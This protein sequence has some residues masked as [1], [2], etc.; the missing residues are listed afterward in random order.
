[1]AT[2]AAK[3][4]EHALSVRDTLQHT[5]THTATLTATHAGSGFVATLAAKHVEHALSVRASTTRQWDDIRSRFLP[6]R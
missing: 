1:V 2:L 6:M 5:A 3:H 4:V